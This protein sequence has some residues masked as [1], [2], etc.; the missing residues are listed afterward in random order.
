MPFIVPVA[1]TSRRAVVEAVEQVL[2]VAEAVG[3][4]A[5][6]ESEVGVARAA[7]GERPVRDAEVARFGAAAHPAEADERRNVAHCRRNGSFDTTE[8]KLGWSAV[9][10]T[11]SG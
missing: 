4:H 6:G 3:V 7:R 8:P 11:R 10:F 2:A 9:R 1:S 5:V